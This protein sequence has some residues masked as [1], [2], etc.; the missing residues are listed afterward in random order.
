MVELKSEAGKKIED[1]KRVKIT[2]SDYALLRI[3]TLTQTFGFESRQRQPF[4]RKLDIPILTIAGKKYFDPSVLEA[5]L[6]RLSRAGGDGFGK[7]M[8]VNTGTPRRH[9][10]EASG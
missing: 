9:V 7:T 2:N 10:R 5:A 8:R 6:D 3:E 1:Y 4:L